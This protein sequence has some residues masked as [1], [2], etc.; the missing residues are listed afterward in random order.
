MYFSEH[1]SR[2]TILCRSAAL[3][4]KMS[5]YLVEQ[6][7]AR[8]NIDVRCQ[9]AVRGVA[10]DGRLERVT[11]EHAGT[12]MVD[13]LKASAMF[14]FIGAAPRTPWLPPQ[15]AT[16]ELGFV[17]TGPA[18][19][20]RRYTTSTGERDPYLYETSVPGVFAVGDVRARSVKRVASAVGEGSVAVQ[21]VH[22]Y[23][24]S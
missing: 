23:L 4:D 17:L 3:G 5:A 15:I 9:S 11:V 12:G 2:V 13:E 19:G 6:I 14:V 8:P 10:G 21:F 22:Q 20:E 18:L 1:A 24:R 16:D 7:A